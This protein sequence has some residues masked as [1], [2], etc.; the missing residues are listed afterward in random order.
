[1]VL[2]RLQA[3]PQVVVFAVAEV[4]AAGHGV[5]RHQH[6]AHEV[7]HAVGNWLEASKAHGRLQG[8]RMELSDGRA[9][10]QRCAASGRLDG[11]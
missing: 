9:G 2:P 10:E 1:M 4:L 11:H 6:T 3:A 5:G 8:A 7:G